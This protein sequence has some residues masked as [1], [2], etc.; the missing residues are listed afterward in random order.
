MIQWYNWYK[1]WNEGPILYRP[2]K[3]TRKS[4]QCRHKRTTNH[5]T[6]RRF[7]PW[8]V[9]STLKGKKRTQTNKVKS[10]ETNK[11]KH[12]AVEKNSVAESGFSRYGML[13]FFQFGIWSYNVP[14]LLHPKTRELV[15]SLKPMICLTKPWSDRIEKKN[16]P[17]CRPIIFSAEY[18]L[19]MNVAI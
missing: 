3:R 15:I 14:Y 2:T 7:P 19:K 9:L 1:F 8:R 13:C 18:L 4:S 12:M 11:H 17:Q 16:I 10:N 5:K 6:P